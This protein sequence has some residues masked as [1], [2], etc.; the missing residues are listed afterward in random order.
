VPRRSLSNDNH[1][2]MIILRENVWATILVPNLDPNWGSFKVFYRQKRSQN[3]AKTA[4]GRFGIVLASFLRAKRLKGAR[5]GVQISAKIVAQTFSRNIVIASGL[6]ARGV[7]HT[8]TPAPPAWAHQ[9]CGTPRGV[10]HQRGADPQARPRSSQKTE[11]AI[12]S[13]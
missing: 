2:W 10:V 12:L 6:G 4:E 9:G 13:V 8:P 1:T 7:A 11:R 3:N 5:V